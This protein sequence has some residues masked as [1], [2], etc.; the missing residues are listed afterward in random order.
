M[1]ELFSIV[2]LLGVFLGFFSSIVVVL[3]Q[4]QPLYRKSLFLIFIFSISYYCFTIFLVNSGKLIDL[5]HF[6]RTGSPFF[7]LLSISFFLLGRAYLN[8]KN[9][10]QF[11]DIVLLSIPIL[12]AMEL[13][14]FY[15]KSSSEKIGVIESFI[16]DKGG[17]YTTDTSFIS[18]NLHYNLQGFFGLLS[19]GIILF[20]T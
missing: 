11:L 14:P 6:F 12:H 3:K 19:G 18:T 1:F 9:T 20:E 7:Y 4:Q 13:L 16:L 8:N 10:P 2:P 5:P 17:I 15:L